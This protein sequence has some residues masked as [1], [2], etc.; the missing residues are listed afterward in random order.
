M[1]WFYVLIYFLDLKYN[2]LKM[3]LSNRYYIES[4]EYL[5]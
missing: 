3:L 1:Q 4:E 5:G 2:F